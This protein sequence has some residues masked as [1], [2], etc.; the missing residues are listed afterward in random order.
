ME[1]TLRTQIIPY[2]ESTQFLGI[3]LDCRLNWEEHFDRVRAKTKRAINT[4]KVV[5]G[6]KWELGMRPKNRAQC[7][8]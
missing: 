2:K 1:N 5:A 4:N 3:T 8:V 6:K 7:G